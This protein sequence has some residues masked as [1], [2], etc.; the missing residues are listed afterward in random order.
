MT[1]IQGRIGGLE[2]GDS[3]PVLVM[4]VVNLTKNSFYG[5]SV[6]SGDL[7]IASIAESMKEEGASI[8]DVGARST[9]PYRKYD[10]PEQTESKLLAEA[11]RLISSKVNLPI[12]ADT[13]RYL[14]AKAALEEGASILNDVYGLTQKD[15]KKLARL[16]ASKDCSLL[17]AAH[18]SRVHRPHD[19]IVRIKDCLEKSIELAESEGVVRDQITID[20]GIGFFS[21]P[22]LSNVEWNCYAIARLEELRTFERPICVGVSRKRFIGSLTGDKPADLRLH[23]SLAA[24]AISVYNGAHVIRTHDVSATVEAVRVAEGMRKNSLIHQTAGQYRRDS[25]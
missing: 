18:E 24:T 7:E 25:K 9:A 22:K 11:I 10:I 20:P 17:L 5:G 2:V 16:A 19:P 4:G 6:R 15:S 13:T 23:G 3:K 8:I 12:S 14:P 1:S 21:D